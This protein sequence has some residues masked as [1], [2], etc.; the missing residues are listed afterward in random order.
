M[1]IVAVS[2]CAELY[3][4]LA[5]SL[6]YAISWS[7]ESA[8]AFG[9]ATIRSIQYRYRDDPEKLTWQVGTKVDST[10]VDDTT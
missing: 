6:H 2:C 1:C 10:G 5:F 9:W 4:Y 7:V 3:W 8:E